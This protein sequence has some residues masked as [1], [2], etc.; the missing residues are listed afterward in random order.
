VPSRTILRRIGVEK[1]FSTHRFG[2]GQ[3]ERDFLAEVWG[4][5]L[6]SL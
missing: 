1:E 3:G 6:A 2:E 4:D 5:W